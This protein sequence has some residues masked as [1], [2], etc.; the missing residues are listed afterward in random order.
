[1]MFRSKFCGWLSFS[2]MLL[3][4]CVGSGWLNPAAVKAQAGDADKTVPTANPSREL[5]MQP[6]PAYRIMPPDTISLEMLKMIPISPYH[7][8][9]YDVLQIKAAFALPDQP[10]DGFFLVEAEGVVALG[11]VYGSVKVEGMTIEEAKVAVQKKLDGLLKN[12]EVSV[13]LSKTA[14][15]Q[16]ITGEYLVC[17]DGTINL[18]QYGTVSIM[19][20]TIAEAC[21][22]VEKHLAKHFKA[23][24]VSIDLKQL[25]S[26]VYYVITDGAGMGDNIRRLPV[27]GN[28][29][30]LDAIAATGGLSQLS[31]KKIWIARPSATSADKGQVLPVDYEA[32]TQRGAT[33]TNYQILPGDR[34]FIAGDNFI[35]MNNTFGKETAPIERA[36]GMM[37]LATSAF[38]AKRNMEKAAAEGPGKPPAK[39]PVDMSGVE[40]ELY[41][42]IHR[43]LKQV[44]PTAPEKQPQP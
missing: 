2:I 32:I 37:S 43:V 40:A 30:V 23:P 41:E 16:Q 10:I 1:M 11:P 22:A 18:R 35:A 31:S 3:G 42:S 25:N 7:I 27:T 20:K 34:V 19:G 21:Q 4:F 9:I 38:E 44:V 15:T 26:K 8:E 24:K 6:L 13:Q 17:P 5:A 28:E 29:T 14:N 36:L 12:P 33:A 39:K